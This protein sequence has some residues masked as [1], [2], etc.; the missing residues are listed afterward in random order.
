MA[1]IP[2]VEPMPPRNLPP[3]PLHRLNNHPVIRIR[4]LRV[5]HSQE[6]L[7]ATVPLRVTPTHR[8]PDILTV[9]LQDTRP[10]VRPQAT[11][12]ARPQDTAHLPERTALP[13]DILTVPLQDTRPLVRHPLPVR[14]VPRLLAIPTPCRLALVRRQ[15][16]ECPAGCRPRRGSITVLVADTHPRPQRPFPHHPPR[17]R[18]LRPRRGS[19]CQLRHPLPV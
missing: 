16:P 5:I 15:P 7:Q 17:D 6:H 4:C 12:P 1:S 18:L 9:P 10:L 13:P 8:P 14:T 3:Q 11:H 19:R 2:R